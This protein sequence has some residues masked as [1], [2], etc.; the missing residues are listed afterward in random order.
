MVPSLGRH[1]SEDGG[2]QGLCD[3]RGV[4][5]CPLPVQTDKQTA[6]SSAEFTSSSASGRPDLVVVG[7]VF[8]WH[9]LMLHAFRC[10]C[11]AAKLRRGTFMQMWQHCI[12]VI[13]SSYILIAIDS[14]H[15]HQQ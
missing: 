5:V 11:K 10:F 2:K 3:C 8:L 1:D 4:R 9:G 7:T 13:L 12:N 15:Q 14:H 6:T